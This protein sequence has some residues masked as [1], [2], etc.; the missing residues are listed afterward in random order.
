[1]Q[2]FDFKHNHPALQYPHTQFVQSP[3]PYNDGVQFSAVDTYASYLK[4]IYTR[5]KLPIYDK[6]PQVK[7]KKYINLVLIEKEDIT[8]PE[9]HQFMRATVNGKIDDIKK[10][11]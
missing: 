2:T 10:S 5:E 4:S 11:K 9:A 8:K 6:W 7:S 1:M 3:S